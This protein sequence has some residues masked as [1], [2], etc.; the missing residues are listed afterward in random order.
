LAENLESRQNAVPKIL[1]RRFDEIPLKIIEAQKGLK[2][3]RAG[4][5]SF[6]TDLFSAIDLTRWRTVWLSVSRGIDLK[7]NQRP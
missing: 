3:I 1:G 2:T 5:G 7:I 4:T 6:Q